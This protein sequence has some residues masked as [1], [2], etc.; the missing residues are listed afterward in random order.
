MLDA[1]ERPSS[2]DAAEQ[3]RCNATLEQALSSSLAA[4]GDALARG[5]RDGARSRLEAIDAR[6]GG[7]T[8]PAILELDARLAA[9]S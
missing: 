2:V 8:A 3:A 6:Y 9:H 5:D 7:L 4:A 1:L